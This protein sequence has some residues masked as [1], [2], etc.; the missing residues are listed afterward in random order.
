MFLAQGGQ[1]WVRERVDEAGG[2]GGGAGAGGLGGGRSLSRGGQAGA[3]RRIMPCR[4]PSGSADQT[5]ARPAENRTAM[6]LAVPG[7]LTRTSPVPSAAKSR[8]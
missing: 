6:R 7:S 2:G 4:K 1:Q 8:S 5:G 3:A